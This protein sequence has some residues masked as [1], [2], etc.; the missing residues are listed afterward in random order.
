MFVLSNEIVGFERIT[1]RYNDSKLRLREQKEAVDGSFDN[2][3]NIV[4][5]VLL[6]D[7]KKQK[8]R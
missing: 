8:M 6:L 3:L 4:L 5:S 1:I 2:A 7:M